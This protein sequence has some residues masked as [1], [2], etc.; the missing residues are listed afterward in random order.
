MATNRTADHL[1]KQAKA[2]HVGVNRAVARVSLSATFSA[3]DIYKIGRLPHGAILTGVVFLPGAANSGVAVFKVGIDGNSAS[4]DA[5]F[6]SATYSAAIA[7]SS[8]ANSLG[9][10]GKGQLSLS[11]ER[12][13]RYADVTFV[14][15][16]GV[17][18]GHIGDV[19]L[20]YV[21]D[22]AG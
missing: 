16:A 19:V 13:V 15:T 12:I 5:L 8:V 20:D 17:S 11:D 21:L 9:N 1:G 18:V 7:T 6:A 10:R 22:D 2:V 3:G 14:P 4:Y